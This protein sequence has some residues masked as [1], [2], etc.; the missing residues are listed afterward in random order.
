M[1]GG[2]A[3]RAELGWEAIGRVLLRD[4]DEDCEGEEGEVEHNHVGAKE[5]VA[6]DYAGKAFGCLLDARLLNRF[7]IPG[8]M[9]QY[10][11]GGDGGGA[12]QTS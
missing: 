11:R 7:D 4:A 9:L 2:S 5:D 6:Q 8:G 12:Y 3:G 1:G 10:F